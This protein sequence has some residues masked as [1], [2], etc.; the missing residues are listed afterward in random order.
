MFGDS[1]TDYGSLAAYAQKTVLAPTAL[2][3]WSGVTFS[4]GNTVSQLELRRLLGLVTPSQPPPPGLAIPDPYYQLANATV[5]IPGLGSA[6]APSFAIG[7]ATSSGASLYD[8]IT[9]PGTSTPLSSLIPKLAGTGVQNQIRAALGQGVRPTSNQLTITQGGANDLLIAYLQQKPDIEAVLDDVMANMRA[10]LSVQ[11]RSMGVR[12]LLTFSLADFRGEVDGVPY[13]M[14]FL[15]GLLQ[16]ASGPAAPD[17]LKPW[18]TFVESGGLEAFQR[19]YAAM[20]Q[21]LAQ[22]FP[23]AA[24][25]YV[26]PEFGANWKLYGAQLGN[27]ASYGIDNTLAYA[28]ATN[29]ALPP[30]ATN[31]FLYFDA[32]HNSA[33]GQAMA[34][35]AM[36]LT[37]EAQEKAIRAA[38]LV[39]EQIGSK[40]SDRLMAGRGNSQLVG[41]AGNDRLWG[42]QGNDVLCG[43]SGNDRISG[44]GGNDWISGGEGSDRLSGGQGADFFAYRAQDC[45]RRWQDTIT[46]FRGNQ[47]DRLGLNAVLDGSDP[48]ANPGWNFIGGQTFT[49]VGQAQLRFISCG[50]L[51]GDRDGDGQADLR[52]QLVGVKSFDTRWIS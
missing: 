3:A 8:V 14:P 17:W 31:R 51:L 44:G 41:L 42:Q 21:D 12:Q 15:S 5:A 7:G 43:D 48:F 16:Q 29:Q 10:S 35:K 6:E 24:L 46:D 40:R 38:T 37:L 32:I 2:P 34:A 22:Q 19:D 4:N 25:L 9:V 45:D 13:Q 39:E 18:K 1:L 50:W 28:Q 36:A 30:A 27:F 26:S 49:A 52:I 23:Y 20:V 33:S 11:L 47:G